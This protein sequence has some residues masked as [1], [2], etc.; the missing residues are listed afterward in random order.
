[1]TRLPE[2]SIKEFMVEDANGQDA[3]LWNR[4]LYKHIKNY[5][6]LR[7]LF[8]HDI[9]LAKARTPMTASVRLLAVN[10]VA[11]GT[12]AGGFR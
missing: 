9:L 11:S 8:G 4:T 5:K 10:R 2:E 12:F 1:M 7:I 6:S 3:D